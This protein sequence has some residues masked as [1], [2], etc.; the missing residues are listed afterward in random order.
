MAEGKKSF[1]AYSD[2][3]NVFSKLPD[4]VAGKLIK[5]VFSYVNDENPE[6]DDYVINALFEQIKATLK[7]DLDKW[8]KQ[9][10]QRSE[11][12]KKSAAIRATKSNDRSTTVND[13]S[14]K[15]NE[16]VRNSTVSCKLLD[17][18]DS[19]SEKKDKEEYKYTLEREIL[20]SVYSL[21]D[22]KYLDSESKKKKW[23]NT[24]R[25]LIQTDGETK[26]SIVEVIK[27]GRTDDFW[28]GNFLS[29]P[30]LRKKTDGVSKFDKIKAKVKKEV[31]KQ[32]LS[33]KKEWKTTW[34]K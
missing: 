9:R 2:W 20:N 18:S 10:L 6:C 26:E 14:T 4:E 16:T 24:I 32:P 29:I 11:A 13:R 12:G 22:T 7:R 34:S 23:L 27:F 1:I 19:V 31:V 21:F 3:H 28:K 33:E 25:L 17:V 8:D 15:L 5:H 30:A